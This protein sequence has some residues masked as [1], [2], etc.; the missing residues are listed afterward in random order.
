MLLIKTKNLFICSLEIENLNSKMSARAAVRPKRPRCDRTG[1][2]G[3]Q[4]SA[5]GLSDDFSSFARCAHTEIPCDRT[6]LLRAVFY[7]FPIFL[8][9]FP[10][11]YKNGI[12]TYKCNK[13]YLKLSKIIIKYYKNLSLERHKCRSSNSPKLGVF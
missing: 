1:A 4:T 2:S 8:Q 13:S 6:T 11:K 12:R 7:F 5:N 3:L 10:E 9:Y